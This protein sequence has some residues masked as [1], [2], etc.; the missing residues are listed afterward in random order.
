LN[1]RVD[2]FGGVLEE[3]CTALLSGFFARQR[4][5]NP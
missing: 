1:H 2:V 5:G 3:Q 4:G